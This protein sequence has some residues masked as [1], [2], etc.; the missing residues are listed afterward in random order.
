M[1][2]PVL[3]LPKFWTKFL[4][5]FTQS[6]QNDTV[7][8]RIDCLACQDEFFMNTPFDVKEHYVDAISIALHPF[9]FFGLGD[10]GLSMYGSRFL[11][12]MFV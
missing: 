2:Q 5:T 6:P 11:P 8:C 4:H 12:R 7:V 9:A 1:K 10:F 3:L